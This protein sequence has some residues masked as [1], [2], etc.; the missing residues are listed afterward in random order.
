MDSERIEQAVWNLV[1]NAIKFS[2]AGE[3]IEAKTLRR[4]SEIVFSVSDRGP[5]VAPRHKEVIF[6]A[7][8]QADGSIT[9]KYGGTGIGLAL[10]KRFVEAHGGRIWVE[11]EF[12]KGSKFCFSVPI[13]S[14]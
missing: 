14:H 5:G 12:G 9:R 11:S 13:T 4:G 10:A 1:S 6:E 7:F 3:K 8:R 2:P